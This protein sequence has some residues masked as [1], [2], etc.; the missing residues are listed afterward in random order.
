MS[1]WADRHT[2]NWGSSTTTDAMPLSLRCECGVMSRED[3]DP[4]KRLQARLADVE[5]EN[6]RLVAALQVVRNILLPMVLSPRGPGQIAQTALDTT[7][8]AL[9]TINIALATI[10]AAPAGGSA[11]DHLWSMSLPAGASVYRHCCELPQAAHAGV[12]W[13]MYQQSGSPDD[14]P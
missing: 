14:A 11:P 4:V 12:S 13:E 5:S 9:D 10:P 7:Q 1:C 6:A 8:H 3:V 2:F